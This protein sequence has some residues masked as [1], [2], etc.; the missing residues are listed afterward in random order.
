MRLFLCV[1]VCAVTL[2]A[3]C[4]TVVFVRLVDTQDAERRLAKLLT[5]VFSR[6]GSLNVTLFLRSYRAKVPEVHVA[7]GARDGKLRE[8]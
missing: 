5:V 7:D 8:K 6:S 3:G 2:F 4:F 1:C